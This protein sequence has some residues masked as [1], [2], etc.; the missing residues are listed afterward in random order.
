[1][2]ATGGCMRTDEGW[3]WLFDMSWCLMNA[4]CGLMKVGGGLLGV[5]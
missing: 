3:W 4:V 1:M 5:N 2:G